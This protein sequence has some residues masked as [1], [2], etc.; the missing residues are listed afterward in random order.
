MTD[1][2]HSRIGV[3]TYLAPTGPLVGGEGLAQLK[4]TTDACIAARETDLI[5][6]LSKVP[7]LNGAALDTLLDIQDSLTRYGG[8]LKTV[9]ANALITD[10]FRISGFSEYVD[11]INDT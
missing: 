10:I 7:L 9:K 5:L 8:S 1:I 6:D 4:Q 2:I 11:T 3:I